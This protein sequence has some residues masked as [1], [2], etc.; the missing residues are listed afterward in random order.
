MELW[1]RPIWERPTGHDRRG[2]CRGELERR[3]QNAQQQDR[4]RRRGLG[5]R[6]FDGFR[7]TI[8]VRRRTGGRIPASRRKQDQLNVPLVGPRASGR[9]LLVR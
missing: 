8:W 4:Q 1:Q 9:V 6:A 7:E 5:T 3:Q 2:L